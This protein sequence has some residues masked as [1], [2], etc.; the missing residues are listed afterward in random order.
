MAQL[1]FKC[2]YLKGGGNNKAHLTHITKYISTREGVEFLAGEK[3]ILSAC[4][5]MELE[6][7]AKKENYVDY[8]ATRPMVEKISAHGLFTSGNGEV[9]LS[10]VAK[11]V[12]Q[13]K[14]NVWL[15]IIALK[16]EDAEKTGYDNVESWK[17]LLDQ[18]ALEM[19]KNFKI[20]DKNFRWYGAF[21][22]HDHH[23][24]IHMICYSTNPKEGFL[25]KT[26]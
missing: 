3:E 8:I 11:E 17:I 21:H 24:H 2:P 23:P 10:K 6:V 19:A 12:A 4:E 14:G 16:R 18:Y 22:N 25:S 7:E 15:P 5:S 20:S 9:A 13:H 1:I 26:G